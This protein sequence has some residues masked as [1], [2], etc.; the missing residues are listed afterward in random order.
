M[1][2]HFWPLRLNIQHGR[3]FG[4]KTLLRE[5]KGKNH[6]LSSHINMIAKIDVIERGG[7]VYLK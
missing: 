4:P 5:Q 3:I 1:Q 6:V 2:G 7:F